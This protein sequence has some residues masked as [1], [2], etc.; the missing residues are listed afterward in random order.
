MIGSTRETWLCH[1]AW[2]T[3]REDRSSSH[4][5]LG[6]RSGRRELNVPAMTDTLN[7][8]ERSR[9]MSRIRGKHTKPELA[10][11]RLVFAMG[12]RYRLHA[13][14]LPGRP[15]LVF[16]D[17]RMAIFVHGCFWHRHRC[18]RGRSFPASNSTFWQRKFDE[19]VKR[20]KRD[21]RR[22]R[23]MGWKVL[24]VWEC[25]VVPSR[26][27]ALARRISAFLDSGL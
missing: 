24:V 27:P 11:R 1:T 16:L 26:L 8:T 18:R 5:S 22:L 13:R 25:Q 3:Y 17:R 12:Y 23:C 15:D 7:K 4:P 14:H 20:D 2:R 21:R 9:L 10:V 6:R 19:N